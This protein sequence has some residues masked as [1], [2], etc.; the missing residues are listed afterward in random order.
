MSFWWN[1]QLKTF[2]ENI[3]LDFWAIGWS[4]V[5]SKSHV[6]QGRGVMM[7]LDGQTYHGTMRLSSFLVLDKVFAT[8]KGGN[9][10]FVVG[11]W[12]RWIKFD[13]FCKFII[14][15]LLMVQK[16]PNN[17]R[18]GCMLKP[19]ENNGI[20]TIPFPQLVNSRRI[21]DISKVELLW[22][23]GMTERWLVTIPLTW[24]FEGQ[25]DMNYV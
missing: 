2:E 7:V 20:S 12:Q 11:G 24:M 4:A 15:L 17:H 14:L 25:T 9:L 23:S 16:S 8:R 6:G 3:F 10:W 22:S 1:C 18:L 21:S 19:V 13:G 5:A